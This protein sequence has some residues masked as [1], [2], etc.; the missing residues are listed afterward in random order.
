MARLLLNPLQRQQLNDWLHGGPTDP[1]GL[2]TWL[3]NNVDRYGPESSVVVQAYGER[4]LYLL[5]MQKDGSQVRA[6]DMT[7]KMLDALAWIAQSIRDAEANGE[8]IPL[9]QQQMKPLWDWLEAL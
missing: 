1:V 7:P 6:E 3:E 9:H 4:D 5:L 2:I 8:D